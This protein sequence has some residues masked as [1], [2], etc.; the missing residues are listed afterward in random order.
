MVFY[1]ATTNVPCLSAR[2]I[3]ARM[4]KKYRCLLYLAALV[5][6]LS[7]LSPAQAANGGAKPQQDQPAVTSIGTEPQASHPAASSMS[8]FTAGEAP[9]LRLG[10]SDEIDISVFGT[11]ELAR[12]ARVTPEGN[13]YFAPLGWVPV[14]GLTAEEAQA[15]LESRLVE[16]GF[17]R[18][19]QVSINVKEYTTQAVSVIGEVVK[20]GVYPVLGSHT[21]LDVLLMAGGLGQ[22]AGNTVTITHRDDPSQPQTVKIGLD[23]QSLDKNTNT[24]EVLPGDVV[25]VSRAGIVYVVGEVNRPGGFVMENERMSMTQAI[26]M[27]AGP[28]HAAALNGAKMLRKTP[29]GL[30]E[31]PVPLKKVLQA[32]SPDLELKPGDIIFIPVSLGKSIASHTAQTAV[33][34]AASAAI[35]TF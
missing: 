25:S 1:A 8:Q 35:Y 5:M 3:E 12:H 27:A 31:L 21:L 30:Q 11:P 17:L 24:A 33:S 32:K 7:Q 16:G 22:R 18:H 4:L 23:L 6:L 26:A 14:V 29:S 34:L 19:P 2:I 20:P 10:P 13:I 28:T 9:K 15:R